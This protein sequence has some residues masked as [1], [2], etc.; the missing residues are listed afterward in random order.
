MFLK[1][2]HLSGSFLK[3]RLESV[4]ARDVHRLEVPSA[5]TPSPRDTVSVNRNVG[6]FHEL[7][8]SPI[9][10]TW[11]RVC[12]LQ[13]DPVVDPSKQWGRVSKVVRHHHQ[14]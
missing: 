12:L 10:A 5:V 13:S 7:R 8:R 2:D 1:E 14:P 3:P 9:F 11:F 4:A 6:A